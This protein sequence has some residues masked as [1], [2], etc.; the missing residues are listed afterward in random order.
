[1]KAI[2]PSVPNGAVIAVMVPDEM[3]EISKARYLDYL[4]SRVD[5]LMPENEG[6]AAIAF[7][8]AFPIA[9]LPPMENLP[10]TIVD[11]LE[12]EDRLQP[13]LNPIEWPMKLPKTSSKTLEQSM[14]EQTLD[15]MLETLTRPDLDLS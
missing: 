10:S 7:R 6:Q 2:A 5:D 14:S 15:S 9:P 11:L 12:M 13:Y 8:Q 1:M 3:T 4:K